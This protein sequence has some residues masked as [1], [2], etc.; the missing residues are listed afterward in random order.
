MK[1]FAVKIGLD[2]APF[3]TCLD[4]K[5]Y[6][7]RV[8]EDMAVARS[9]GAASTPTV[10]VNGRMLAGLADYQTYKRV[11]DEALGKAR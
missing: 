6:V 2:A 4:S 8:R 1:A 11:I 9:Q 7:D 3:G 5:R 10:F